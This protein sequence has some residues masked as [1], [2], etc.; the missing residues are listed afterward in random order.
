[1]LIKSNLEI[2]E[3]NFRDDK[4][5]GDQ[6]SKVKMNHLEYEKIIKPF[7]KVASI[8]KPEVKIFE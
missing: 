1:M 2:L 8:R 3:G 5:E 7:M 6:R 4:K